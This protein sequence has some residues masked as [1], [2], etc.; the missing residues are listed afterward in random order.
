MC[1][2]LT[3]TF[4]FYFIFSERVYP[5]IHLLLK[6][7]LNTNRYNPNPYPYDAT[8]LKNERE[9]MQLRFICSCL[10]YVTLLEWN[11]EYSAAENASL[12]NAICRVSRSESDGRARLEP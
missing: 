2:M 6:S 12:A 5:D 8:R 10:L 3:L 1:Q 4:I 11:Y 9:K 7:N